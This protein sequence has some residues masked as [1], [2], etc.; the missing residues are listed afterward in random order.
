MPHSNRSAT[1]ILR[2]PGIDGVS[3]FIPPQ[4]HDDDCTR[5]GWI[6]D[7]IIAGARAVFA[8]C[9]GCGAVQKRN[10]IRPAAAA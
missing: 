1:A 10:V 9:T 3:L 6:T 8:R 5:P 2:R 7:Q 4:A